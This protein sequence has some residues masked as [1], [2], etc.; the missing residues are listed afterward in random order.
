[1]VI[2]LRVIANLQKGTEPMAPK[3]S[4]PG[5]AIIGIAYQGST[6]EADREHK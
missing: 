4:R 2:R 5:T 3:K 6:W 1:M